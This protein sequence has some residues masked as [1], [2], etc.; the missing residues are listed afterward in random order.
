MRKKLFLLLFLL[1]IFLAGLML[2]SV[3]V[4]ADS[5]DP[6]TDPSQMTNLTYEKA[7][8]CISQLT[9][10]MQQIGAA[11]KTNEAQLAN[12]QA[13]VKAL[14]VSINAALVKQNQLEQDIKDRSDKVAAS[15]IVL[16]AKVREMYMKLRSEP[17]WVE[18][19][20]YKN[21][22]EAQR[23]LVYRQETSD[24]DKQIIVNLSNEITQLNTDK[25]NVEA[26]R[27]SLTNLQA[28]LD[29]QST[30]LAGEV[31][32]ANDYQ[33]VLSAQISALSARQ[34]QILAEKQGTFQTTV[35]DV[36]LA[37]DYNASIEGFRNSAPSGDFAV[38][39]FGAPHFKGL[40][41]YGAWGRAKSGQDYQTILKAYYGDV[42]IENVDTGGSIQTSSGSMPFE[43]KYLMGIAEMPSSWTDNDSAAL[44]A[45]AI[46][47]RSYALAYVG[48][49]MG[50]RSM[51]SSICTSENCQVWSS[52][53]SSNPPDA[54]KNAVESTRGQILVSNSSNEVV[55][56]WYASTSGGYQESYSSL[57]HTTP[58]F[59]DTKNGRNGWTS[60]AYEKIA[61]S[62]WFY[63]AW[64]KN[65]S[66]DDCGRNNPWLTP[67]ELADVLNAWKVVSN[68]TDDR[69]SP[70]GSCWGGNPYSVDE[71]RSK[72]AGYGG[73][74]SQV[75]SVSVSYSDGGYTSSVHFST[76]KGGVDVSGS[77][78]KKAFN[79]RA[80]GRVSLKS[81]L[82]NIEQK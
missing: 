18:L 42:R 73:G 77:D 44:K 41:Q 47:A 6:C 55:N 76:D 36:P 71:L 21:L 9:G 39:S 81:G 66:G 54:W 7:G 28:E 59:W 79:L 4:I 72:A 10:I 64:Y 22:G 78:F 48:W 40:S 23:D 13:R 29:K 25:K 14:Q 67:A 20:R 50:D 82:F 43:D 69:V 75:D 30:F 62:P 57:G 52:S 68:T 5:S 37:D 46:A 3:R 45:Q 56:A 12:L 34:Q 61:G 2:P 58:A 63:K 31:K 65:R 60:D 19:L 16:A 49:R 53:K 70:I 8:D 26:R 33:A 80:P 38:F 17:L 24:M 35:G 32:K 1:G 74:Y 15:Y 51:K 27:A 11:N